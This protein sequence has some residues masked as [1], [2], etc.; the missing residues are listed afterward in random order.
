MIRLRKGV[1]ISNPSYNRRPDYTEPGRVPVRSKIP[2][3]AGASR[4]IL[5]VAGEA[6]ADLHGAHLVHAIDRLCPGTRFLGIGGERMR[7]AGVEI[8]TPS[9]DMAVV[10][11]TEVISRLN[12]II[13]AARQLKQILKHKHPDLLILIDY[14][15]FNIY[16]AGIARRFHVP[17]LYYI[18]PQ[19]W[20]W[21]RG[22]VRKM[23]RRIDRMAVILPFE[24]AFYEKRGITVHYVGH[25]LMD[26]LPEGGH[27]SQV[28][29]PVPE[30]GDPVIGLLPG[31]RREEIRHMLPVML[32]SVEILSAS[33]PD[34]VCVLPLADTIDPGFI[35]PLIADSPVNIHVVKG[36]VH[37][38]L[39]KC[40]VA[41]VTS[42][43]ATLDAAV[44][45]VP[46]VIVYR[47]SPVSYWMGRMLIKVPYIGLV[48][49]I[50]GERVVPEVIQD[51]V[52]PRR[53]AKEAVELLVDGD[54]RTRVKEKLKTVRQILGPGGASQR[55]ARIAVDMM[56][57]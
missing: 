41:L 29:S 33:Y 57:G 11:L 48:N 23:A 42:G 47:V 17:V 16:M 6:S 8:L 46:M 44:M 5:I 35:T 19:V 7:Q 50:A 1:R 38:A 49:L 2:S 13:K 20:A 4:Q 37:E 3:L 40:R 10:G 53:L 34:M 18:S 39:E 43:T 22:R 28:P 12:I 31:S 36:Q 30:T 9:A 56:N 55:T 27:Q 25:P 15:D 51:A 52:T 24:Q 21:R 14:P 32:K 26:A 45:G 54:M